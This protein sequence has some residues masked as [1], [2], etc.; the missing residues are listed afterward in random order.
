MKE[1]R[2]I[3]GPNLIFNAERMLQHLRESLRFFFRHICKV[4]AM[5]G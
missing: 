2:D 3:V 5:V 1:F 4:K